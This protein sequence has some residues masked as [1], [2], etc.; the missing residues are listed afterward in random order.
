VGDDRRSARRSCPGRHLMCTR[1]I[2]TQE[3]FC[4]RCGSAVDRQVSPRLR[5][6]PRQPNGRARRAAVP[7]LER[8]LRQGRLRWELTRHYRAAGHEK[9]AASTA[10]W[11]RTRWCRTRTGTAIWNDYFENCQWQPLGGGHPCPGRRPGRARPTPR[12]GR[13]VASPVD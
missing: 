7:D 11:L 13:A 2:R 12:D 5:A 6:D 8:P 9:P 10:A 4:M 1:T 3:A